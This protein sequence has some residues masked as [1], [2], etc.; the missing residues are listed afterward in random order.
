MEEDHLKV[1]A[2]LGYLFSSSPGFKTDKR[3][4]E[5]VLAV[6]RPGEAGKASIE[7]Q[8]LRGSKS[9]DAQSTVVR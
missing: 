3:G 5:D 2:S 8:N 7:A 4:E 1:E 9:G 6:D